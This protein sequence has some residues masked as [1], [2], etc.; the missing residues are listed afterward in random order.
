[1]NR[2]Y[3]GRGQIVVKIMGHG[4]IWLVTGMHERR[5]YASDFI[6]TIKHRQELKVAFPEE[7]AYYLIFIN[8]TQ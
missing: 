8:D 6:Q 4:Y 1:M 5:I 2:I 3:L 7:I